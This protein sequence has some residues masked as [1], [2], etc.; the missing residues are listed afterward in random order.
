MNTETSGENRLISLVYVS[1]SVQFLAS[2]DIV[3][4]LH[5]SRERNQQ[6]GVTGMLLY[7]DGNFMQ[8]LEGLGPDVEKIMQSI[9]RDRRH[10][11]L[12]V[13]NKKPIRERRFA[14]WSMAFANLDDLSPEQIQGASTFLRESLL[15]DEFRSKPD[16]AYR[17]LW[18]FKQNMR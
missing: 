8:A 14:N 4:L 17:L 5:A 16:L 2:Q 13:L 1:S 18:Q 10:R 15:D 9:E 7:K 6:L 12:I 11:G 3:K